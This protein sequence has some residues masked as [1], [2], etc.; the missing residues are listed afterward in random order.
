MIINEEVYLDHHG[1]KGMRWGVRKKYQPMS[2]KVGNDDITPLI[3]IGLVSVA[4][5]LGLH[6]AQKVALIRDTGEKH[7][8]ELKKR[9]EITNKPFEFNKKSSL[10][11]KNMSEDELMTNVVKPINPTFGAKGT[12]QNCRRCT[13]AYEMRRRGNDVKATL[14]KF[15]SGQDTSG[16]FN[17]QTPGVKLAKQGIRNERKQARS[18]KEFAA[19]VESRKGPFGTEILVPR[20][21][22]KTIEESVF[23]TIGKQP[24]GARGDLT[25]A[26]AFGGAHS[27]AWEVVKGKPV[28]FDTQSGTKFTNAAELNKT[29]GPLIPA[30]AGI[31][32]L[33]NK[34]L[35]N[36][37]LLRWLDNA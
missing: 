28:I 1:V 23:E 37:F 13:Y 3:A 29:F 12:K 16:E 32:R 19:F 33:D 5:I 27:V 25:M 17:A 15:A 9:A 6:G 24:K 14:S 8:K 7:R 2:G 4:T 10:A 20:T 36:D 30:Q 34:P 11:K 18:R 21:H 26:W 31:T 22:G 35:N